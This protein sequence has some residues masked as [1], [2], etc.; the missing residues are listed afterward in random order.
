M[1]VNAADYHYLEGG[2]RRML[3]RL[4]AEG[5]ATKDPE[6]DQFLR[7]PPDRRLRAR[8]DEAR[9]HPDQHQ[10]RSGA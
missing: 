5:T 2:L 9:R 8:A 10:P 4:H 3:D 6:A 1:P 7:P